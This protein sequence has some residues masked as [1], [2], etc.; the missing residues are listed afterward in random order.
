MNSQSSKIGTA[1][2]SR[3][4]RQLQLT[5]NSRV[6][7]AKLAVQVSASGNCETAAPALKLRETARNCREL[8]R[9]CAGTAPLLLS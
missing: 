8:R 2:S 5:A 9:N 3:N 1:R 4:C 6:H 7:C